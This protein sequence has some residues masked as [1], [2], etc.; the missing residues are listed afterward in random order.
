MISNQMR[1]II[2]E[3]CPGFEEKYIVSMLS[4]GNLAQSCNDCAN[5]A[6]GRCTKDLF[7]SLKEKIER[8]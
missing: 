2:A 1:S 6:N 5:F 7:N 8:N 4:M 3:S